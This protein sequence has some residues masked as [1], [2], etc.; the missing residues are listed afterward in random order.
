M[1]WKTLFYYVFCIFASFLFF[2]CLFDF[3]LLSFFIYLLLFL[4]CLYIFYL[5]PQN[6]LKFKGWPWISGISIFSTIIFQE[7]NNFMFF[8]NNIAEK[9][10][11]K[12]TNKKHSF[13]KKQLWKKK[14][15]SWNSR[16]AASPWIQGN[17]AEVRDK[18]HTHTYIYIFIYN[19]ITFI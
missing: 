12:Q 19:Y 6:F 14:Q 4:F 2:L 17:S 9:A 3:I 15:N 16:P 13:F 11:K 1:S 7:K 5:C 10:D 8:L 18:K